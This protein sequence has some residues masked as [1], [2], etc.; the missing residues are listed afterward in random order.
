MVDITYPTVFSLPDGTEPLPGGRG[1]SA[2]EFLT[3]CLIMCTLMPDDGTGDEGAF[4]S[5][6]GG[7]EEA[8]APVNFEEKRE[9]C[10]SFNV[11]IVL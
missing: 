5:V 10:L 6:I 8:Y 7:C 4:S 1:F 11:R 2:L 3:E 9:G